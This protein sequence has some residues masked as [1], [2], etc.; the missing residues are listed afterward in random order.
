MS[1]VL[2]AHTDCLYSVLKLVLIWIFMS[3]AFS[4][5]KTTDFAVDLE[6][7]AALDAVVEGV[8]PLW[9]A[10]QNKSLTWKRKLSVISLILH[11]KLN[12]K[13]QCPVS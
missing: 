7:C 4:H 11:M 10:P 2:S 1:H 8:F 12:K 3:A 5:F 6:Y 13:R 9:W